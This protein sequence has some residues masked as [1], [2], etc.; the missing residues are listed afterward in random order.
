MTRWRSVSMGVLLVAAL[1]VVLWLMS[2]PAVLPPADSKQN[3]MADMPGMESKG[4]EG[5][6]VRREGLGAK[7]ETG[8]LTPHASRPK[9]AWSRFRSTGCKRSG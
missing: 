7:E 2:R 4:G 6:G 8:P 9:R 3:D 1:V 5:S